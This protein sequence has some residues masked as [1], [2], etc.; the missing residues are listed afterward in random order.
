M[1]WKTRDFLLTGINTWVSLTL[2]CAEHRAAW[3]WSQH[4]VPCSEVWLCPI[5]PFTSPGATLQPCFDSPNHR[6]RRKV[7]A[8]FTGWPLWVDIQISSC[9]KLAEFYP[10][11]EPGK[12]H[13]NFWLSLR[14]CSASQKAFLGQSKAQR[15]GLEGQGFSSQLQIHLGL[16]IVFVLLDFYQI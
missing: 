14:S 4:S 6:E 13:R 10:A 2:V 1:W 11:A 7:C 8:H 12:K 9:N 15:A 5:Q 16:G 3:K